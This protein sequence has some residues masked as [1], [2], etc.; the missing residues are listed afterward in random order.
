MDIVKITPRGYC[1]GVVS[2]LKI[3]TEAAQDVSIAKP[4]Y[5]LGMIVHNEHITKALEAL[6]V[7][8]IDSPHL[9]RLELLDEID[10]GTVVFT[11]HGISPQVLQK[12]KDKGLNCIDASCRDVIKTHE[13]IKE[14]LERGFDV[15]YLGKKGHPET[16]GCLGISDSNIHLV[17]KLADLD[18][19]MIDNDDIVIT[20]QTTMSSW[21]VSDLAAKISDKFLSATFIK[22]ICNA[23]LI[24]QEAVASMARDVDLTIVVGD[25]KSNN[26]KRLVQISEEIAGTSAIR[27]GQ[28]DDLDLS[29]LGGVKTVAV[30]SGAST[31]T[32]ITKEVISFLE[33]YDP[34]DP[35]THN[36]TS[37]IT[38][39]RILLQKSSAKL[40]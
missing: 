32:I 16:E 3:V 23:T 38:P 36:L 2:A 27:I 14:H 10:S 33:Q 20:N 25:V 19:L 28:L 7:V 15:I 40:V 24:R 18:G 34:L 31:P 26:S 6:G 22:E 12:A 5:V 29:L 35:K 17:E 9:T 13:I 30:T 37:K 8:T 1:H 4:V 39:E 21:D 11:A